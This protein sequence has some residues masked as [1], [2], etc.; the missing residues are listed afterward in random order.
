[1]KVVYFEKKLNFYSEFKY[2]NN[3]NNDNNNT[4]VV[5]C[6]LY[7]SETNALGCKSCEAEVINILSSLSTVLL[8]L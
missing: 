7:S 3:N 5:I 2:N 1:M 6:K 4:G 8:P